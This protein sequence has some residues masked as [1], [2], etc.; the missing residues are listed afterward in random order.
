MRRSTGPEFFPKA[1]TNSLDMLLLL[2]ANNV[3]RLSRGVF[4]DMD[5]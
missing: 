4:D 3:A 2:S 1:H 5:M